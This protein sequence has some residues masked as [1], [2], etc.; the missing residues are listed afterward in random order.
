M[1]DETGSSLTYSANGLSN[2]HTLPVIV[3]F[4]KSLAPTVVVRPI[5]SFAPLEVFKALGS[6]VGATTLQGREPCSTAPYIA[7]CRF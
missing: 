4:E 3:G 6:A 1:E 2:M 7:T 5:R